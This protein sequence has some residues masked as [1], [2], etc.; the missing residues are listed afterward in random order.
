MKSKFYDDIAKKYDALVADDVLNNHFPYA[1]N[2]TLQQII[3]EYISDNEEKEK[4]KILDLGIGTASLYEKIF[5][6]RLEITGID[7]CEDMLEIAKLRVPD[8]NLIKHDLV[9]GL[10]EEIE[11]NYFDY[12]VVTYT[13]MH[14]DLEYVIQLINLLIGKLAP[15]GKIF[16][17]DI[18]FLDELKKLKYLTRYKENNISGINY[19]QYEQITKRV[20]DSLNLSFME[21]N[22][23]TGLII[24][25][26]L[27]ES[28][29]HYE[30]TLVKYKTNTVKWKSS[31]PQKK[32]E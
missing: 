9:K 30:E 32:S 7:N 29:L 11:S 3:A 28:S 15:F 2:E 16:I 26:K 24:V 6:E 31:H 4:L 13:F 1:E 22:E 10:P 19:H 23:Y 21:I 14:F 20:D 27:Y 25:E 17:G 12:I 8:A 18:I 5:P